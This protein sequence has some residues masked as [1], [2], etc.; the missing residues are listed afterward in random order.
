MKKSK[1]I[2][3]SFNIKPGTLDKV[4]ES[5]DKN[6]EGNVNRELRRL[7]NKGLGLN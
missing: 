2:Q 1:F 5:A 7:I 3:Y 6:S 4:K